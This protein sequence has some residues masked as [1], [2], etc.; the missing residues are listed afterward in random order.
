M[1]LLSL[2]LEPLSLTVSVIFFPSTNPP[3]LPTIQS[4]AVGKGT[5]RRLATD[6]PRILT[7]LLFIFLRCYRV[8]VVTTFFF[9]RSLSVSFRVCFRGTLLF[10]PR[11]IS[12]RP[13][14]AHSQCIKNYGQSTGILSGT[15]FQR[16][17]AWQ[18]FRKR[19]CLPTGD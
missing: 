2:S 5:C 14:V 10:L 3:V 12:F 4:N 13:I 17:Q 16:W 15:S 8:G 11:R 7:L 19:S 18:E 6:R 9:S 1:W